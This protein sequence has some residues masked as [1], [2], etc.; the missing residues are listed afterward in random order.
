VGYIAFASF[1]GSPGVTTTLA[2]LAVTWPAERPLILL[3]A[4]PAGGDLA[5]RAD[6]VADPGLVSLAAAGRR[7]LTPAALTLHAQPLPTLGEPKAQRSVVVAPVA[8]EQAVAALAALRGRLPA[9]LAALD[10]ADALVDCGRLDPGSP[11]SDLA[12]GADLLV[13]LSRPTVAD[14]HHLVART[15]ALTGMPET[16][17]VTIG[18]HP[19]GPEQVAEAVGIPALGALAE[20]RRA[21]DALGSAIALTRQVRRSQLLRSVRSL[22]DE[23]VRRLPPIDAAAAVAVGSVETS[24]VEAHHEPARDASTG[25]AARLRPHLGVEQAS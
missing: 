15:A 1:K 3:E 20:D 25:M 18:E 10:D 11:A 7:D 9:A 2:A 5:A 17:L 14:V 6:L 8:P 19:Y 22:T 4:D 23:L 12:S 24:Q 16:V 13:L 21:A